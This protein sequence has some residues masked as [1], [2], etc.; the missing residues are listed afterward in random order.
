M[1]KRAE[2]GLHEIWDTS[3]N[4]HRRT[5]QRNAEEERD[6]RGCYGGEFQ[7][8]AFSLVY[9]CLRL[10][11]YGD[12]ARSTTTFS[13]K[14]CHPEDDKAPFFEMQL[15]YAS[16]D[17][18]KAENIIPN[19]T[20]S[21]V[22]L[23]ICFPEVCPHCLSLILTQFSRILLDT[24][25]PIIAEGQLGLQAANAIVLDDSD[26]E[27]AG[28][29]FLRRKTLP[30]LPPH[31]NGHDDAARPDGTSDVSARAIAALELCDSFQLM[32]RH[33]HDQRY[34]NRPPSKQEDKKERIKNDETENS[35]KGGERETW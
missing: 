33:T 24:V 23:A 16:E 6:N 31:V 2:E 13:S 14:K 17:I 7:S 1:Q 20:K 10:R 27:N 12:I 8:M 21:S 9:S 35:W 22:D 29:A 25:R 32:K 28:P 34:T 19:I 18:L 4:R 11:K 26:D 15:H 3:S 5:H 30:D